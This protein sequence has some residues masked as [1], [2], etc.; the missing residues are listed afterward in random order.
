MSG[1]AAPGS[2]CAGL[3]CA[4]SVR[5]K[6]KIGIQVGQPDRLEIIHPAGHHRAFD[7]PGRQCCLHRGRHRNNTS[8]PDARRPNARTARAAPDRRANSEACAITQ[9]T[10]SSRR[11]DH[12]CEGCGRA[13]WVADHDHRRAKPMQ[14]VCDQTEIRLVAGLPV[15]AVNEHCDGRRRRSRRRRKNIEP[16][17]WP[18]AIGD[19]K[20]R[21]KQSPGLGGRVLAF[22]GPGLVIVA[23]L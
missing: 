12:V 11:G 21:R 1:P 19:I 14:P 9:R 17:S 16:V 20:S 6:M 13:Q 8:R 2:S 22:R 7:R 10:A 5:A 23:R 3:N 15:A 18:R 4:T